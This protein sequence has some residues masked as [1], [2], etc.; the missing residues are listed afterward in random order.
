MIDDFNPTEFRPDPFADIVFEPARH[1]NNERFEFTGPP[2]TLDWDDA[3]PRG[4]GAF[5]I[6]PDD[7]FDSGSPTVGKDHLGPQ[8]SIYADDGATEL[9]PVDVYGERDMTLEEIDAIIAAYNAA[10]SSTTS[11]TGAGS[12]TQ[13]LGPDLSIYDCQH[14]ANLEAQTR[15]NMEA[16]RNLA[17]GLL[18]ITSPFQ[19]EHLFDEI[20]G[21]F[22]NLN[23]QGLYDPYDPVGTMSRVFGQTVSGTDLIDLSMLGIA[24]NVTITAYQ[25]FMVQS[26][27]A[28]QLRLDRIDEEQARRGG[29][30]GG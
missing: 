24:T 18:N 17:I 12:S 16:A 10:N 28:A 21:A 15:S 3:S 20:W 14:L 22:E 25:L 19:G 11:S 26:A 30:C 29:G 8:F 9:P 7:W 23:N 4:G 13:S 1:F 2:E 5:D 6:A 27:F